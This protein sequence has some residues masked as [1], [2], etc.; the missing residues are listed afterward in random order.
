MWKKLILFY[1]LYFLLT[2]LQSIY[3]HTTSRK[4]C[5]KN[6]I[7]LPFISIFLFFFSPKQ[8]L[9]LL[10]F[11][12]KMDIAQPYIERDDKKATPRK[13]SELVVS[14]FVPFSYPTNIKLL[15]LRLRHDS[16]FVEMKSENESNA[17]Y[18]LIFHY[19]SNNFNRK[20]LF[21]GLYFNGKYTWGNLNK[22]NSQNKHL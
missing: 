18:P 3:I 19:F 9:S 20:F 22:F 11:H 21:F 5:A 13:E 10:V 12:Y 16:V 6:K 17:I 7:K 15:M 2:F 4:K 14:Q 1:Y 8:N